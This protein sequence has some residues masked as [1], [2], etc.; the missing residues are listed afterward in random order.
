M[1]LFGLIP[2][3]EYNILH[4]LCQGE[5]ETYVMLFV[6]MF[7]LTREALLTAK[8]DDVPKALLTFF[9]LYFSPYPSY[10]S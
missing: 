9:R 7:S 1:A 8:P 2:E 10:L 6:K 3:R 4:S 5:N